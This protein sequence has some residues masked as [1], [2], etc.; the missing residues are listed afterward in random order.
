MTT[1]T[2]RAPPVTRLRPART[3]IATLLTLSLS[4]GS[5]VP[6]AA[7][8]Q[9]APEP[10]AARI[11]GLLA[12]WN[13]PD[14]PGCSVGVRRGADIVFEKGYGSANL[15][16]R[17]AITPASVFHVASVAKPFTAMS[18]LLLARDG[19]IGLDDEVRRHLPEWQGPAGVTIRN[20]LSHT[21][22]V[23]DPYLLIELAAP[24]DGSRSQH[25]QLVDILTRQRGLIEPPATRFFYNNGGYVL[26]AEIVQRVSGQR[27]RA[28][29]DARIL[30]PLG[31]RQTHLH[32]DLDEIVPHL[33]T[34]YT[35]AGD[36]ALRLAT[37]PGGVVGP[38]G[39]F[40]TT[41][42]L[43]RWTRNFATPVVGDAALFE[44]MQALP[45]LPKGEVTPYALGLWIERP[46]G[47]RTI[48][49]GGGDPG[50]SAYLVRYPEHDLGIAVLCN[51]D[52]VDATGLASAIADAVLGAASA[53]ETAPPTPA[54][55]GVAVTA[56]ALAA[57]EGLYRSPV[58]ESLLRIV[59]RDGVLHGNPGA[60]VDGGW[61][62]TPLGG[63]RFAIDTTSIVL[64]FAAGAAGPTGAAGGRTLRIVGERP[65][66]MVLE[67][68]TP[69]TAPP[70][71]L[72][73]LA[74]DYVSDELATI[75]TVA[76]DGDTVS[77]R[78]PGRAAITLQPIRHDLFAGSLVGS[79]S[80]GRDAAG[81][82]AGFTIHAYA[83]RGVRFV[84]VR[85]GAAR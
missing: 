13:R 1:G 23:R 31:M 20:L 32:D 65:T 22:G 75:G 3:G 41:G 43:L 61:P 47:R 35:H 73:A 48:A 33:A 27:L 30:R 49:H 7:R 57:N 2:R 19:K 84:R 81:A 76:V 54:P 79:I 26:L 10:L 70:G 63:D 28:F 25:E 39:L 80:F 68:V 44:T 15:E 53:A 29:V 38:A 37:R 67:R 21:A 64:E 74:G 11:D 40:T 24:R 58:D 59:V 9:S 82:P 71:A 62:V 36:G 51:V 77:L 46:G 72:A 4:A 8:D 12:A 5:S 83:A 69:Y 66:P 17:V 85:P 16:H 78:I 34:G 45:S 50:T 56:A 55:P 52:G 14:A 42:D 18:I 6:S 60:G